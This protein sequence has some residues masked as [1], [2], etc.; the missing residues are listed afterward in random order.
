MAALQRQQ[1]KHYYYPCFITPFTDEE[2]ESWKE[3]TRLISGK[4][5]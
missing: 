1:G 2:I 3:V 5:K 4:T